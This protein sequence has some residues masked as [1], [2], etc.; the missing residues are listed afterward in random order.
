MFFFCYFCVLGF[1]TWSPTTPTTGHFSL[2]RQRSSSFGTVRLVRVGTSSAGGLVEWRTAR[3]F[4]P[5]RNRAVLRRRSG[6]IGGGGAGLPFRRDAW[7]ATTARG[8]AEKARARAHTCSRAASVVGPKRF[9][10][11]VPAS[12]HRRH[13]GPMVATLR[14][15]RSRTA[16]LYDENGFFSPSLSRSLARSPCLALSFPNNGARTAAKAEIHIIVYAG[17]NVPNSYCNNTFYA[18]HDRRDCALSHNTDDGGR[19]QYEIVNNVVHA[20]THGVTIMTTCVRR[21]WCE[22]EMS[23]AKRWEWISKIK[24]KSPSRRWKCDEKADRALRHGYS[25]TGYRLWWMYWIIYLFICLFITIK[26][27]LWGQV[28]LQNIKYCVLEEFWLFVML[29][30]SLCFSEKCTE[31]KT[32]LHVPIF[33]TFSEHLCV[34]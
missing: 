29:N 25:Q 11:A 16:A 14:R 6:G 32:Q 7:P 23:G 21:T 2:C 5:P 3:S 30:I 8:R 34:F 9:G 15:P 31:S 24:K 28:C 13:V 33:L 20:R 10:L 17:R 27:S 4:P 26:S 22:T 12:R 19:R 18:R 1:D